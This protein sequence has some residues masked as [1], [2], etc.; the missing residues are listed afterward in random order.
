MTHRCQV[1]KYDIALFLAGKRTSDGW[2]YTNFVVSLCATVG[3]AWTSYFYSIKPNNTQRAFDFISV[4]KRQS[5]SIYPIPDL[6][7]ARNPAIHPF[8]ARWNSHGSRGRIK[9][10]LPIEL[11]APLDVEQLGCVSMSFVNRLH[12]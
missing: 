11:H 7:S 1:K 2:L 4:L 6:N 3:N 10:F 8:P 12:G 9:I 5:S